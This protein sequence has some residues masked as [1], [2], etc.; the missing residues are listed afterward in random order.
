MYLPSLAYLYNG[1][2]LCLRA[3]KYGASCFDIPIKDF[4]AESISLSTGI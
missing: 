1:F 2:P 4:K 3:E